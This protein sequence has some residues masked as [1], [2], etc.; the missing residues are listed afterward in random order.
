MNP[1]LVTAGLGFPARGTHAVL[2]RVGGLGGEA[3]GTY[4]LEPADFRYLYKIAHSGSTVDNG[5]PA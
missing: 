3:P 4:H 5:E 2:G 1:K